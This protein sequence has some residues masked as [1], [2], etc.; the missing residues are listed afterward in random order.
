M[1]S[2]KHPEN[3]AIIQVPKFLES[4]GFYTTPERS[5]RMSNIKNKN[6][7]AEILLRKALWQKGVRYQIHVKTIPG[8]PD[9]VINKYRLIIFVDGSFW[10]GYNWAYKKQKIASNAQFWIP[11]IERNM[12]R[13]SDNN[14]MLEGVGYT[15]MRFWDHDVLKDLKKCVNQILLY[16]EA[17]K[18]SEIPSKL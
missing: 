6:T 15:V 8:K 14:K 9:I 12:Q 4:A 16:I 17:A 2:K 11:K 7:K 5:E 10:H 13:D 1:A 3:N 18:Y